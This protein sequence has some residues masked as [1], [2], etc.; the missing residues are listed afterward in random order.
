ML[1]LGVLG[2][3]FV[4]AHSGEEIPLRQVKYALEMTPGSHFRQGAD[5]K[6]MNPTQSFR[7]EFEKS[8]CS[9]RRMSTAALA[10]AGCGSN[11]YEK[12]ARRASLQCPLSNAGVC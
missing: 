2:E 1:T 12:T 8:Q 3:A 4:L 6:Q 10:K 5:S 11:F 9:F 7:C